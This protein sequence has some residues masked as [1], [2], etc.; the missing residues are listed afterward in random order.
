MSKQVVPVQIRAILP[1]NNGR[2]VFVG[3]DQKVFV[4]YVDES[5]G[6]ATASPSPSSRGRRFMSPAKC[7]RKSKTA[8]KSSGKW[9][10]RTR[11]NFEA[12]EQSVV[13]HALLI[14]ST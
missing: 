3:N 7:G 9:R 2:A 11:V 6:P 14:L 1:Y 10:S 5:V 8:R 12:A 13:C 4:I